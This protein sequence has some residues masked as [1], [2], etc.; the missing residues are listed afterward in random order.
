ME[1][2]LAGAPGSFL[3]HILGLGQALPEV[4]PPCEAQPGAAILQDRAR[5]HACQGM[6]C[7]SQGEW[8][9]AV[10]CYSKAINLD[11]QQVEFYV[12]RAEAFLQ[13][14]DFQSAVLNLRKA[15]SLSSLKEE[16]LNR[17]AFILCLQGQCLFDQQ[18]YWDALESF[19]QASELQPNNVVY[20]R[21]CIACLAALNRFSDCLH[22][23]N[24]DLDR[25]PKNP[26]LYTLRARLY[27]HF[28]KVPLCYQ[29]IQKAMVLE[30]QHEGA[31]ALMQ[32]LLK[33]AQKAKAEAVNKA[34]M[35]DLGEAILKINFALENSPLEAEYFIFRGTLYR[36]LK[37]FNAAIDDYIRAVELVE[38]GGPAS[39]EVQHQLLLTYN[40]FAV[41]CYTR[42]CFEEALLLLNKALKADKNEK[43]LYVNR[44]DCL[45]QLGELSYAL[46][47]YQQALELSPWDMSLQRRVS[48]LLDKLGM[49][50]LRRRRYQQAES[51]FSNAIDCDPRLPRYFLHRAKSRMG[52]QE[53][54]GAKEDVAM[55]LLLDPADE[56]A[57][58]LIT[59]LFPGKSVQSILS[60]KVGDLA[61]ALLDAKLQACPAD[62]DLAKAPCSLAD[63][64]DE[65]KEPGTGS[66]VAEQ[67]ASIL[68]HAENSLSSCTTELELYRKRFASGSSASR[69]SAPTWQG[70]GEKQEVSAKASWHT[71]T[72]GPQPAEVYSAYPC[73]E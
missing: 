64:E 39:L 53:V 35:G 62:Q 5:E 73:P 40:D 10:L 19:T 36:R 30:P 49:R 14:C 29:D 24:R 60:S 54:M 50:E 41:H 45:F 20:H 59:S 42:G 15:H 8:E 67:P 6:Q 18:V 9:K 56:E 32:K 22:L 55:A 58:L 66:E 68:W 26:D 69:V 23:V 70:K 11:P 28:N 25:D 4:E 21:K 3:H 7:F 61:R 27:D 43:G 72:Q 71:A 57:M 48:M 46:A 2:A 47:D 16:Y 37:D 34:L 51:Y 44:G 52:L 63:L 33:R 17:M 13:L 12:Q 38:V 1:E 31:Q 65:L